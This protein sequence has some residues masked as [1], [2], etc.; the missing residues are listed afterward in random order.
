MNM[1]NMKIQKIEESQMF[2]DKVEKFRACYILLG[3]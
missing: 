3:I 1:S 2:L